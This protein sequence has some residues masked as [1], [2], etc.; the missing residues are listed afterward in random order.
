MDSSERPSVTGRPPPPKMSERTL[1][2]ALE[3]IA[4]KCHDNG[5]AIGA[6]QTIEDERAGASKFRAKLL[7]VFGGMITA[8][9]VA[10]FAWMWDAQTTSALQGAA[11]E[12]VQSD[13]REHD[14]TPPGHGELEAH[15]AAL[16]RR[17]DANE[18]ATKAINARLRRMEATAT[19]RNADVLAELRRI[20]N[21]RHAWGD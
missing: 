11:I 18:S 14:P 3:S 21:S 4:K 19:K 2:T 9:A 5:D 13:A 6:L 16:D 20:R 1:R 10:G 17:V 7:A 15:D 12:Q 8:A